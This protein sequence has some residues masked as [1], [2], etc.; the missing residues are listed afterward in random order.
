MRARVCKFLGLK[1]WVGLGGRGAARAEWCVVGLAV[2]DVIPTATYRDSS[3]DVL[4][5]G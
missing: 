4:G 3:R 5:F 1:G 2:P